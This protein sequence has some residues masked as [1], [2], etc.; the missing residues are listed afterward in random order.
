MD[1]DSHDAAARAEADVAVTRLRSVAGRRLGYDGARATAHAFGVAVEA[2]VN[3]VYGGIPYAV[4]MMTPDDVEDFAIGFS[5]TEGIIRA[6]EEVRGVEIRERSDGLVAAVDLAAVAQRRHL[7]RR[8]TLSGRTSCGVCGVE[9]LD[10]VPF[11]SRPVEAGRIAPGAIGAALRAL[12][13]CQ[14]LHAATGAAHAAAWC[15]ADGDLRVVRED[16]GRHNALDKM[17]GACLRA[18]AAARNGLVL[19]TSRCSFEMVEKVAVFGAPVVVA[20]SAPTTL[21]IDRATALGVTLIAV[22]RD[23]GAI[24]FTALPDAEG[25]G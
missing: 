21:A 25:R 14:P 17:I 16:V 18:G 8:R 6:R 9:S 7:S 15:D 1:G 12:G 5:L 3:V 11:A 23:D 13:A 10:Q 24:A 22:A 20:I 19:V 4:M 2:P